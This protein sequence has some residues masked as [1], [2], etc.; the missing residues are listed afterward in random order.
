MTATSV[1]AMARSTTPPD[2]SGRDPRRSTSRSRRTNSYPTPRSGSAD[3]FR[4]HPA[5]FDHERTSDLPAAKRFHAMD[6]AA[7]ADR[8]TPL[9]LLFPL[10]HPAQ[11]ELLVGLR[12]IPR[13]HSRRADRYWAR[14]LDA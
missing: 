10:S 5:R 13:L 11:P 7:A 9:F 2:A 12:Q 3:G 8:R 6:G 1:P 14:V 4:L